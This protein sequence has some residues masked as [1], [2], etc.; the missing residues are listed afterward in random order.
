M[1]KQHTLYGFTT[2]QWYAYWEEKYIFR[3]IFLETVDVY[4]LYIAVKFKTG[5][6]KMLHEWTNIIA[7]VE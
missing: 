3:K 4:K 2:F 5:W 7:F 1:N 6:F